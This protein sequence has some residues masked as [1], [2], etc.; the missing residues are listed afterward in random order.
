MYLFTHYLY[1]FSII[2]LSVAEFTYLS[3]YYQTRSDTVWLTDCKRSPGNTGRSYHHGDVLTSSQGAC[4]IPPCIFSDSGVGHSGHF[5]AVIS[6]FSQGLECDAVDLLGAIRSVHRQRGIRVHADW[7]QLVL[8]GRL[9][10]SWCVWFTN[11]REQLCNDVVLFEQARDG[12]RW[13]PLKCHIVSCHLRD[14]E[15]ARGSW[16]C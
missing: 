7:G 14:G 6:V 1:P 2:F 9:R 5:E 3:I 12:E 13:S 8:W 15:E 16:D 10:G 4:I 11:S